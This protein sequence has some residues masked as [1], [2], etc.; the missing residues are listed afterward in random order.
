[1]TEAHKFESVFVQRAV[2]ARLQRGP[3]TDRALAAV[4]SVDLHVVQAVL[5]GLEALGRVQREGVLWHLVPPPR[6]AA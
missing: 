3:S 1:M 4:M 2:I 5:R 6:L